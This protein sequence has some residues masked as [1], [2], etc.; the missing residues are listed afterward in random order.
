MGRGPGEGTH[1]TRIMTLLVLYAA[2]ALGISFLCSILEAVLLS[3]TPTYVAHLD[4]S[5]SPVAE[6][7]RALKQDVDRPLAAIL[8]L[9][10]VAH[11]AGAAGVGAQTQIVFGDGYLALASG[12]MTLAVLVISEIIPKSLGALHWRRLAPFAGRVLPPLIRLTY[13]LV[14]LAEQITR[15]V[16][17]G[18]RGHGVSREEFQ[19]LARLGVEQGLVGES[20][21]RILRN[22]FLVRNLRAKDV[23]TPRPVVFLL[24]ETLT[25][26]D[27][28]E[29]Q[30][31]R[32]PFSRIPVF[33]P[34]GEDDVHGYVLK[35]DILLRAAHDE[36]RTPLS[37]LN[38]DILS[39][40]DSL[41]L[42]AVFER[43]LDG[44]ENI[45]LVTDE[46]G[47]MAGI[48]TT[49]DVVETLLGLE[50]VDEAD[51]VDDMRA[52]ARS[53]WFARAR[54]LGHIPEEQLEAVAGARG[55]SAPE[56]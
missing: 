13:P 18:R 49:E 53:R 25:V 2:V 6:A 42:P 35:D 12:V 50:I 21:S 51:R 55:S 5:A 8:S 44:R 48:V 36:D 1:G 14:L 23:M 7:I 11:T 4:E 28:L 56:K 54:R 47:G 27:V 46:Y 29:R 45:A 52:L 33:G 16:S 19:A 38:R 34:G 3:I 40:P 31:G 20:E 39:V 43:L 15:L 32:F 41:P 26:E 10:T 30:R 24:P 9:N 17:A 37:A 22:L